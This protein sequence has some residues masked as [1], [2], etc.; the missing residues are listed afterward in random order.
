MAV[1]GC[2]AAK[3]KARHDGELDTDT[4]ALMPDLAAIDA[5]VMHLSLRTGSCF[6]RV[7]IEILHGIDESAPKVS[8]LR[9][10]CGS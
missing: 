6:R 10:G 1:T 2:Q 3:T 9:A 8:T 5:A 4:A 7:C